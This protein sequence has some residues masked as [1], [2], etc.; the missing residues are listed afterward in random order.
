[1][2][3]GTFQEKVIAEVIM[4][5]EVNVFCWFVKETIIKASSLLTAEA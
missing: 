4:V 2:V 1:M 5:E 3:V